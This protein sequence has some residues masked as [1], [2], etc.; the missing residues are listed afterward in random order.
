MSD[1]F[2]NRNGKVKKLTSSLAVLCE[3][4]TINEI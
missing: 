3:K 2:F 4:K 1:Y